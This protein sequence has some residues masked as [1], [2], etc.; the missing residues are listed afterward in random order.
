MF[1][2]ATPQ[3]CCEQGF[4][5][6]IDLKNTKTEEINGFLFKTQNPKCIYKI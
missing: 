4:K 3:G 6:Q 5:N 1:T 2:A